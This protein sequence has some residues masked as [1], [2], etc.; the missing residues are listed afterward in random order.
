LPGPP[1]SDSDDNG[2]SGFLTFW[3]TLPGILT[4]VAAVITAIVGLV[5]L[6][7]SVGND[8]KRPAATV[9]PAQ[10]TT[11]APS[12]TTAPAAEATTQST[13]RQ[14]NPGEALSHGRLEMMR[15][16]YADLERGV[17]EASANADLIFGPE[18]T[19]HLFG[20]A[21][22]S[23]A[24][25]RG[26]PTKRACAS[27]LSTRNDPFVILPQLNTNLI[28]VSTTEGHVALVRITSVPG[29]ETAPLRLLYTV[30]P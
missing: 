17:T 27:A 8:S 24:P 25:S 15:G 13:T 21:S 5:T 14:A 4:G 29:A 30:W 19:P 22:A 3:T 1:S 11:T 12:S 7:S 20:T 16:D 18:S 28:C 10:V 26:R 23:L 6:L 2:N 9:G